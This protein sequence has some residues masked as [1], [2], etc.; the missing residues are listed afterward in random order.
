M[1]HN[2]HLATLVVMISG[3]PIDERYYNDENKNVTS[4]GIGDAGAEH[5]G[6]PGAFSIISAVIPWQ[7]QGQIFPVDVGKLRFLGSLEGIMY[8]ES[9]AG[10]MYEVLK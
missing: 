9:A 6:R 4:T 2:R 7:G 1:R 5:L 8:V 3:A 10:E